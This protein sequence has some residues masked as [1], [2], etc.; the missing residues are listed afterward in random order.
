VRVLFADTWASYP[1]ALAGGHRVNHCI[2]RFLAAHPGVECRALIPKL[3]QGTPTPAYYPNLADF[4]ALGLRSFRL[5]D[6]GGERWWF[7]CGYPVCA[8]ADV[9]GEF[10]RACLE[11][12]PDVIFLQNPR[13]P[14]AIADA[15]IARGLP[16]VCYL[17]DLRFDPER[18][19]ALVAAGCELFCCSEFLSRRVHAASGCAAG[20]LYPVVPE[21]DYRVA[22]D[23]SPAN[24]ADLAITL[25]NPVPEK[26]FELFLELLPRFPEERF[27][28]VECW[29][30]GAA[31]IAQVERRLAPFPNVELLKRTSEM[32]DVYRRTRLLLVPSRV[33]EAAGRVVVEAQVSGIP[34]VA[35][36]RGGLPEM[37]GEGGR[38]V[39]AWDDAEAW[40][41]EIRS[42]LGELDLYV[43]RAQANAG[44]PEFSPGHVTARFLSAAERAIANLTARRAAR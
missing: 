26:G 13:P 40:E 8:V 5:D 20:V 42:I 27:L 25:I 14:C 15:V 1:L 29:P 9:A 41:Q 16:A 31:G 36:A 32:R 30:L 38:A 24:P 4:A 2:L 39:A 43:E 6:L 11:F 34:V 23:P 3:A 35:S 37:L 19:A 18:L 22:P 10:A 28:V 12:Q 17:H 44:R 7:D 33:E 21:E